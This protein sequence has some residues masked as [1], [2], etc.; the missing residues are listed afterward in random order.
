GR[1]LVAEEAV[2]PIEEVDDDIDRHEGEQREREDAQELPRH[3]PRDDGR[4]EPPA[5]AHGQAAAP[6]RATTFCRSAARP[7]CTRSSR[8]AVRPLAWRRSLERAARASAPSGRALA[9]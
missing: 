9:A 4:E 2:E 8:S 6:R 5:R 1:G 3:V 7:T